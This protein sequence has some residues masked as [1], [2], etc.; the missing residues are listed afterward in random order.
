M[1]LEI[2]R[3]QNPA[4]EG[5]HDIY[6]GTALPPS[7]VPIPITQPDDRIGEPTLRCDPAKIVAIVETDAPDRNAPFSEPDE[8]ARAISAIVPQVAHVDHI[9][10]DV[11]VFVTEQGLADLRGLSPR[12]R[13]ALV[14]DRC[15]H[16]GYRDA[17]R[18]YFDRADR[19]SYGRH[20]PSLPG[21]A[22]SWHQRF[23]DTGT[24]AQ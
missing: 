14:I 18:D 8:N 13:A 10:Q 6:Y 1:I 16:P 21:E 23:L 5:M 4:L 22:L 15:A 3:W 7:R 24:M 19:G 2:N 9:M 11:G 20:A 12:R 17:L